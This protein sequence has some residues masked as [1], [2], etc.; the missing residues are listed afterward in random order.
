[1]SSI[2]VM[3]TLGET[4]AEAMQVEDAPGDNV[5]IVFARKRGGALLESV[6]VVM[7]K[8]GLD[9]ALQRK[10]DEAPAPAQ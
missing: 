9:A 7:P 1:M 6:A 3:G 10:M 4:F 5:R 2:I 8:A